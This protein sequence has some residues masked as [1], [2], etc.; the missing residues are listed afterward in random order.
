MQQEDADTRWTGILLVVL[1]LAAVGVFVFQGPTNGSTDISEIAGGALLA[2]AGIGMLLK[3]HLD[4]DPRWYN[5]AWMLIG[6]GIVAIVLLFRTPRPIRG[7]LIGVV[8]ALYGIVG[9]ITDRQ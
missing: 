9:L 8:A 1:G 6:G 2:L 4:V 7:L 5:V 3:P